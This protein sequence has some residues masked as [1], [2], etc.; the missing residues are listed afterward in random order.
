MKARQV[1]AYL[2]LACLLLTQQL[3]MVHAITH[4]ARDAPA[5]SL[6]EKQLPAEMQCAQCLAFAAIGTG[7]TGSP[8]SAV[9]FTASTETFNA[10]LP[11]KPLPAAPRAFDSRAPPILV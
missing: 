3:G 7:L 10:V 8:P 6:D 5:R 1:L 9:F 2:A 4:I 11:V